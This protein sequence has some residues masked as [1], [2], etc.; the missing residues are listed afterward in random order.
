MFLRRAKTGTQEALQKA[1]ILGLLTVTSQDLLRW[2]RHCSY[3][4]LEE[5]QSKKGSLFL[6]TA[7]PYIRQKG[8]AISCGT[9]YKPA[10]RHVHSH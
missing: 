8:S 3:I 1:V 6:F 10:Q 4:L 9:V 5:R 7:V 2:F